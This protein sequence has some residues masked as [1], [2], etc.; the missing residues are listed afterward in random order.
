LEWRVHP[1]GAALA[2]AEDFPIDPLE[3]ESWLQAVL[4]ARLHDDERRA[5][6]T[7]RK[8]FADGRSYYTH[9][10]RCVGR[11]DDVRWFLEDVFVED[12]GPKEWRLKGVVFGIVATEDEAADVR[13]LRDALSGRVS[14]RAAEQDAELEE[15]HRA[16]AEWKLLDADMDMALEAGVAM[17]GGRLA[18]LGE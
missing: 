18:R 10:F 5:A 16:V 11:D 8:A 9:D 13:R 15:L 3:G 7:A 2:D 1:S 12:A 4:R 17:F 14:T 6:D